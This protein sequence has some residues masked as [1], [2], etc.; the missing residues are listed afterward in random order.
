MKFKDYTVDELEICREEFVRYFTSKNFDE[1]ADWSNEVFSWFR[2]TRL[3]E[4]KVYPIADGSTLGEFMV[5]LCH[6]SYPL[7]VTGQG[8][9]EWY[10]VAV[11]RVCR[12]RLA[13]ECEWGKPASKKTTLAMVLADACKLAVLRSQVKVMVFSSYAYD[14]PDEFPKFLHGIR[15]C[16]DDHDPWLWIDM[17]S[18]GEIRS[19][20]FRN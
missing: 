9:L 18:D 1:T 15:S 20:I 12:V 19:D 4:I 14:D 11:N 6:T 5:D 7:D 10:G 17:R 8:E 3:P 16:H 2:E 13:L